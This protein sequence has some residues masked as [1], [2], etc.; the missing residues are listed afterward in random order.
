MN[1]VTPILACLLFSVVGP[2]LAQEDAPAPAPKPKTEIE[3]FLGAT[4]KIFVKVFHPLGPIRSS[5][6][7][8]DLDA[9]I[10]YEPGKK[11]EGKRGIRVTAVG[12]GTLMRNHA[13]FLDLDEIQDL[14][15][16]LDYMAGAV[17][18]LAATKQD[19]TEVIFTTR[20]D[21][22]AGFYVK[23]GKASGFVVSGSIGSVSAFFPPEG[24]RQIADKLKAGLE[25][26]KAN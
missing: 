25:Y 21:F 16:A 10:I 24:L 13:S 7:V 18:E 20:G 22:Q 15:G 23:D 4:G 26:L 17:K 11:A 8:T 14:I 5:G 6:S 3:E 1:R 19:Y 12:G 2:A 9:L